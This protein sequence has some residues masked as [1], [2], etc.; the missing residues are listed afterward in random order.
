M[1]EVFRTP[2]EAFERFPDFDYEPEYA[3]LDGL[4][5]AYLDEGDGDPVLFLHGEPTWSY[6]WRKVFPSVRDAGFHCIVPDLAGFGR[7]DKPTDIEWYSYDQHTELMATLV[8]R[9]DLTDVTVIV[10]D[11][12]GSIGMRMAVE[13]PDRFGRL[14]AMDTG[15]WTGRQRMSDNWWRFRDFVQRTEDLPIGLLVRNACAT[16]PGDEVIAAYEAP[17]PIPESKAAARAFPLLIPHEPD[18]PGAATGRR[19]LDALGKDDRPKLLLWA[20]DDFIIPPKT[21]KK[22]AERIGAPEPELI[23]NAS[24][25]I[26]EDQG[27]RI[28][29]RIAEWL[30]A[31]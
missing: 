9:L 5:I 7:S 2:D 28:G 29:R 8:E 20:E 3:D 25:F 11:W 26:Q 15:L 13:Y 14:V 27:E 17:F 18:A 19:V 10:H 12:G 24:H 23:P 16:D 22:L 6:L 30:T 21:G 1:T 31:A 4:R